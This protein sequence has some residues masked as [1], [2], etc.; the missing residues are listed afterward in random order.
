MKKKDQVIIK[1]KYRK[2]KHRVLSNRKTLQNKSL[3]LTQL[4]FSGKLFVNER[5]CHENHQLA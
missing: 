4:K 3:D 2:Q 5:M 1:F